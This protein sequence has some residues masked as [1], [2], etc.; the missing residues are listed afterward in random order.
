MGTT[1]FKVPSC[2]LWTMS[3]SQPSAL[4][5]L[6]SSSFSGG[7]HLLQVL[8]CLMHSGKCTPFPKSSSKSLGLHSDGL[9]YG[10]LLVLLQSPGQRMQCFRWPDLDNMFCPGARSRVSRTHIQAPRV[11]A[12]WLLKRHP[13]ERPR[14][15]LVHD[16]MLDVTRVLPLLQKIPTEFMEFVILQL[17]RS[18]VLNQSQ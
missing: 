3:L 7:H 17:W 6:V 12:G 5:S 8:Q 4:L 11:G 1:G 16:R 18:E 15:I 9:S 10:H 2:V 14:R 13:P